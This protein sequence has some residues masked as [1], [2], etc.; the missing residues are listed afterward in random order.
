MFLICQIFIL[1]IIRLHICKLDTESFNSF[2][3]KLNNNFERRYPDSNWGIAVLQ[4]AALP[5]GHTA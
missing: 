5:L 4:T 3:K 2:I 1:K